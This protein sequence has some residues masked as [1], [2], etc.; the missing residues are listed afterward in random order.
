MEGK[1]ILITGASGGM[2]TELANYFAGKGHSLA[3][4][5]N[6]NPVS[7]PESE[8]IKHYKWL[9]TRT[10]ESVEFSGLPVPFLGQKK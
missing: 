1:V 10:I 8:Y 6:N 2:G 3:L 7:I 4:H 5:A 9:T